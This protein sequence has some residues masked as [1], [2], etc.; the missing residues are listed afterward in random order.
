M[1]FIDNYLALRL[2]VRFFLFQHYS[3]FLLSCKLHKI[4]TF[5]GRSP[6]RRKDLKSC[7]RLYASLAFSILS[8]D[9]PD[10]YPSDVECKYTIRRLGPRICRLKLSFRAF[11]V[12]SSEGCEYDYLEIDGQKLCGTLPAGYVRKYNKEL[13]IMKICLFNFIAV[14]LCYVRPL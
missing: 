13:T 10:N 8:P 4:V 11:D 3:L 1:L 6:S 9:H 5:L 12:E 7:N 2:L 14:K